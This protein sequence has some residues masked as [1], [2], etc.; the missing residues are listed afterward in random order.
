MCSGGAQVA[1]NQNAELT[2]SLQKAQA[3]Y[4]SMEAIHAKSGW[5][6]PIKHKG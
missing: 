4:K 1:F 6:T 2:Y 3:S 5:Y